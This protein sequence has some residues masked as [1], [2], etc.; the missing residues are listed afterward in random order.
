MPAYPLRAAFAGILLFVIGL[1]MAG[2]TYQINRQ[3]QERIRGWRRADG[4]VIELLKRPS[5]GG[6]VLI[7]L[8]AFTTAAGERVSVTLDPGSDSTY[9]VTA[10]L[11]VL[12]R[13]DHPQDAVIDTTARRWTRNALAIGAAVILLG[14]G[15]YVAWY[16]SRW[17]AASTLSR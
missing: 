14:L 10:P 12:Y 11:K 3:E 17:D 15:G 1:A 13:P 16:A 2:G 4:T 5:P 6:G 9:Y 8:I 7:P